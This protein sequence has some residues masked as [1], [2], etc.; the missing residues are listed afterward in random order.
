MKER[1]EASWQ[2]RIQVKVWEEGAFSIHK[3]NKSRSS[4]LN[5]VFNEV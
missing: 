3:K 5:E 1:F 4:K 2:V